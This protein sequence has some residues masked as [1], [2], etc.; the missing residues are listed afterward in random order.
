MA[1]GCPPFLS[2][3]ELP[4]LLSW[5]SRASRHNGKRMLTLAQFP[6][7][8]DTPPPAW[9]LRLHLR[10]DLTWLLAKLQPGCSCALSP[11]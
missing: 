11:D 6:L 7:T 8:F 9:Q 4:P 2:R 10:L 5:E 1:N 3:F